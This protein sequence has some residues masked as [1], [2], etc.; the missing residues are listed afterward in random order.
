[1][2][3]YSPT[4]SFAVA[5]TK[6]TPPAPIEAELA[7]SVAVAAEPETLKVTTPP[8]TGSSYALATV[9]WRASATA[10]LTC[11]VCPLPPATVIVK[12]R[13]S[14]AP[15]SVAEPSGREMPR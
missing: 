13:N 4:V 7:E 2:T 15:T 12:P 6:A 5:A 1:M 9:T 10:V 3:L 14:K 8:S 11:V